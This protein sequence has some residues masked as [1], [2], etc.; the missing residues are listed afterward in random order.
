MKN[1]WIVV[2]SVSQLTKQCDGR[3]V[4]CGSHGGK[5]AAEYMI[6]RKPKGVIFNDAG[7]GKERAG[8]RALPILDRHGIVGI[9]VSAASAR[10]G[11]GLDTY[12]SGVVSF[13][14][15]RAKKMGIRKGMT[16][17]KVLKG[18]LS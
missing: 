13:V 2:D 3:M 6:Q 12:R 15:R 4:I 17:K 10:I 18:S 8:I 16:V 14:N 11:D 1:G 5:A 9:A 7:V